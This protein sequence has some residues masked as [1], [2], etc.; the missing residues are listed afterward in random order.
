MTKQIVDEELHQYI[1]TTIL[2][3]YD[4]FDAAHRRSHVDKVIESSLEI[5]QMYDVDIN[6]VYTIAAFHDIGLLEDRKTHHLVSGHILRA[7]HELLRWFSSSQIDVMAQA[8]EDH[9][10]SAA[11]PPRSIY[12]RIVADADRNIDVDVILKRTLQYGFANYP[13][14]SRDE[15]INRA[16][17]HLHEKYG[18]N[19]YLRL[20][21][22]GSSAE[23][24]LHEMWN[25]IDDSV[26]IREMVAAKYDELAEK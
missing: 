26:V 19:G 4:R 21:I 16:L 2:P 5:A 3:F 20:W 17:R 25:L 9:R 8:V 7:D 23:K 1:E 22:P 18:R 24:A 14:L 15:H 12:G 11:N 10:A 6:M 13:Q